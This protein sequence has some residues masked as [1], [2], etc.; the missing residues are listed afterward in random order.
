MSVT[1]KINNVDYSSDIVPYSFTETP[2]RITGPNAGIALDGT[3]IEDLITVKYDISVEV[4]P[5]IASKINAIAS[6]IAQDFV[7][8]TYFSPMRNQT[9]TVDMKPDP[10]TIAMVLLKGSGDLYGNFTISFQQK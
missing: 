9:V 7:S 3:L 6:A 1:F 8:I 10:S 4:R 5:S 2:R